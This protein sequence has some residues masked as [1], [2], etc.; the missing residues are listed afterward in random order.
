MAPAVVPES[1]FQ[2][3]TVLNPGGEQVSVYVTL[4][5][6]FY[7][8]KYYEPNIF[9]SHCIIPTVAVNADLDH[10]LHVVQEGGH[11]WKAVYG[12]SS[13]LCGGNTSSV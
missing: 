12:Y 2:N 6:P 10:V 11:K 13:A 5:Q 9:C 7:G 3:E 8:R 4:P 1:T